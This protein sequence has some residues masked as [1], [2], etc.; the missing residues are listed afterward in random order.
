ML[1]ESMRDQAEAAVKKGR[2]T[3]DLVA[4][5]LEDYS[6]E[7]LGYTYLEYED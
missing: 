5:F 1:L 3:A 6:E 4:E 2:M 7:L